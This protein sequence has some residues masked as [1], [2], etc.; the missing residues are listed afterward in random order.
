MSRGFGTT[1]GAAT[2]DVMLT[3]AV[4][5]GTLTS[6][7]IWIYIN[8]YTNTAANRILD[9]N[10]G[11]AANNLLFLSSAG[12]TL[13]FARQFST[14]AGQWSIPV[15][16]L[17]FWHNYVITHNGASTANVPII[18]LDGVSQTVTTVTAPVGT[19]DTASR[20]IQIGNATNNLRNYDG[21]LAHIAIWSG[22]LLTAGDA[23]DL[24][25]GVN[26]MTITPQ[27]L[28]T[29][30][31]LNGIDNQE[32]DFV[33]GNSTSITGT[34]LGTR[35]PPVQPFTRI[36]SLFDYQTD[37]IVAAIFRRTLSSVG[38]RVG[39]RQEAA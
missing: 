15:P 27:Q 17:N 18:Y 35:D 33:L 37:S 32:F 39:S 38:A 36:R 6:L 4:T 9:D 3:R 24:S 10:T 5:Y 2:T 20:R 30:L 22:V 21:M 25:V 26:P 14:T 12:A 34:R 19:V 29:Y 31:P 11:A 7:S 23:I 1:F 16:S 13:L 8:S 28:I